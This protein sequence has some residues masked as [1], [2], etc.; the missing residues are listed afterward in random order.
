MG[1]GEGGNMGNNF[2]KAALSA[3]VLGK[4]WDNNSDGVWETYL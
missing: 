2:S 1:V 4:V 3:K